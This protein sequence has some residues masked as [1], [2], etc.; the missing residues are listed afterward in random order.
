MPVQ[1]DED[2]QLE[3]LGGRIMPRDLWDAVGGMRHEKDLLEKR[4]VM[5]LAQ[6]ELAE[7]YG[8]AP[9]RAVVLFGPPG[10]GKTTF[11]KA[12]ASRLDW[13][14]VEVFPSRL[15]ADPAGSRRRAARDLPGRSTNSSTPSS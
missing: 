3:E 7:Q 5:P 13:A 14:F 6:P 9:P 8:V 11:A 4:L 15:A 1:R 2:T 12:I 10:T